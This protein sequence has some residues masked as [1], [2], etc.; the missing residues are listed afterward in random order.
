MYMEII[1][2]GKTILVET[3]GNF[4][5]VKIFLK[6]L[7]CHEM[8]LGKALTGSLI[9]VFSFEYGKILR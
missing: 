1:S 8:T 3:S 7:Y 9:S 5:I 6:I 2:L 4:K